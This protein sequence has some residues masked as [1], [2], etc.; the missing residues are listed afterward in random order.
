MYLCTYI[1]GKFQSSSL[2]S[3]V[4]GA[5]NLVWGVMPEAMGIINRIKALTR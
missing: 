5:K 4:V 2:L 1:F 3:T